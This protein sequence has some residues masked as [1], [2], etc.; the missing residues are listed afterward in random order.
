MEISPSYF[1]IFEVLKM[2]CAEGD[3]WKE[4]H[5]PVLPVA[6]LSSPSSYRCILY[7]RGLKRSAHVH[8]C[9]VAIRRLRNTRNQGIENALVSPTTRLV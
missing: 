5:Y 8:S 4:T 1:C 9:R 2:K 6:V 3:P 7:V